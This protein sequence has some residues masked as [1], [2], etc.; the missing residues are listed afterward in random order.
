[1]SGVEYRAVRSFLARCRRL[2]FHPQWFVFRNEARDLAAIA[3]LLH[4]EVVDIGCADAKVRAG[5]TADAHYIGLDYYVTATTW[6]GTHP[7]V[8]G[9]AQALPFA[10][11]RVDRVLLLDVLEHLPRPDACIGEIHRVLKP[12]G[13]LILQVPFLYPIHDAPLDFHRWT[14]HGLRELARQH[15]FSV[16]TTAVLGHPLQTAALLTNIALSKTV[17]NWVRQRNP[18]MLLAVALP[19]AV[20]LINLLAWAGS[21]ISPSETMMPNGYRMVWRKR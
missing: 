21:T 2:P 8:Y 1:M 14:D 11:R 20:L 9:D 6:Y 10:S 13:Q 18:A 4:G 5:L 16:D 19:V 3:G 12:G 7:D 17:M 15:G